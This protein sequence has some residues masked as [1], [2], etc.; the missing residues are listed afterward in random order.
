[1]ITWQAAFELKKQQKELLLHQHLKLLAWVL[2][3]EVQQR[4]EVLPMVGSPVTH[5]QLYWQQDQLLQR[6]FIV[7]LP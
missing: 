2:Q 6:L 1:L 5:W 3:L 7:V 4:Q